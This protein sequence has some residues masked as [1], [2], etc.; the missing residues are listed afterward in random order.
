MDKVVLDAL[1][2]SMINQRI[3]IERNI[4]LKNT[5]EVVVL[6]YHFLSDL[7][8]IRENIDKKYSKEDTYYESVE[9]I[10]CL[11]YC[12]NRL[13]HKT[14]KNISKMINLIYT[15]KYP[16]TYPYTYGNSFYQF[17]SFGIF[18]EDLKQ[19]DANKI[20]AKFDSTLMGKNFINVIKRAEDLTILEL[21]S[22]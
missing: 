14:S 21:K 8:A 19:D 9:E 7:F 11:R 2:K 3:A 1:E 22:E 12:Y 16:Y 5:V 4:E 13:K 10:K 15:K 6:F 18:K 20:I 17:N